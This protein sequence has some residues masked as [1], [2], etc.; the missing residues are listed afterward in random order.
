MN[1]KKAEELIRRLA[2]ALRCSELYSPTHPLFQRGTDALATAA[3]EGLQSAPSVVIGFIGDEVVVDGDR[4]PRGTAPWSAS[5]AICASA[6]SRRS[7][8]RAA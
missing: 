5:R 7:R 6:T 4:L 1:Q 8:C 2:A 3:A